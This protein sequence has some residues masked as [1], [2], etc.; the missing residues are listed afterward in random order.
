M[1]IMDV[2]ES[3]VLEPTVPER[4]VLHKFVHGRLR[5]IFGQPDNS[6]GRDDDWSLRPDGPYRSSINILVNG[7]AGSPAVWIFDPHSRHDGVFRAT[8]KSED[9]LHKI[10]KQIQHRLERASAKGGEMAMVKD[11]A[12][13]RRRT[14]RSLMG[15]RLILALCYPSRP[16]P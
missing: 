6:L 9:A 1:R 14:Q 16:Q 13:P 15:E 11:G 12:K 10:I 4:S 5:E 7:T 3:P 2:V 8:V